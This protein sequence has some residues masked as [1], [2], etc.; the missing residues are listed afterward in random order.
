MH[1]LELCTA[2]SPSAALKATYLLFK[3]IIVVLEWGA[4]GY[5][6]DTKKQG[7]L[8]SSDTLFRVVI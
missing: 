3:V 4:E 8:E 7:L 1:Q 5:V 2:E 6:S